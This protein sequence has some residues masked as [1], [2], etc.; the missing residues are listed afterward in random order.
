MS[1]SQV[2]A[3]RI[4]VTGAR[5]R[6]FADVAR[7]SGAFGVLPADSDAV[8]SEKF[9][10]YAIEANPNF[11]GDKGDPG[12]AANTYGSRAALA[13]SPIANGSAILAAPNDAGVFVWQ[14]GNFTD[15]LDVI[16]ST[17]V[18]ISQGGWVL[19]SVFGNGP[20]NLINFGLATRG[21]GFAVYYAI[22][23]GFTNLYIPEGTWSDVGNIPAYNT[24]NAKR[25]IRL[26][27]A[28]QNLTFIESHAPDQ[29]MA[30]AGDGGYIADF[31]IKGMNPMGAVL[32]FPESDV[33]NTVV[34]RVTVLQE[35]V[36][37][38]A[39]VY[40]AITMNFNG[41][42][43]AKNVILR[44]ITVIN[45]SRMG[46]EILAQLGTSK[47]QEEIL[48]EGFRCIRPQG[49][50][51][52]FNP[53]ISIDGTISGIR[54]HRFYS[55][56]STGSSIEVIK[57][58]NVEITDAVMVRPKGALISATNYDIPVRRL[59][60]SRLRVIEPTFPTT[61]F[62]P[63]CEGLIV[64]GCVM[65]N[66]QFFN[67]A[68]PDTIFRN[69]YLGCTVQYMVF[70]TNFEANGGGA[71]M[72]IANNI[73]DHRGYVGGGNDDQGLD[74]TGARGYIYADTP[75]AVGVTWI[76]NK[77]YKAPNTPAAQA[78]FKTQQNSAQ[79]VA[80][81]AYFKDGVFVASGL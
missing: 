32:T 33:S 81:G 64:E 67:G 56:D 62:M 47:V 19:S 57:A 52:A 1:L 76:G 50:P 72:H 8:V 13:A 61:L 49:Q 70:N 60:V 27:G 53:S 4:N 41:G 74:S 51:E 11:K 73:F 14:T 21:I 2:G 79:N 69:N 18:P 58:D 31:T 55:S 24:R 30:I 3:I 75:G 39:R 23:A 9:A 68:S 40:N 17:V 29:G 80:A 45:P 36:T 65:P 78:Y 42:G 6:S 59:R 5:G 43:K 37:D 71:R 35:P 34:E 44:D 48:I 12:A 15:R 22:Q 46:L 16:A 10:D 7:Q 26:V 38:P 77:C 63:S 66:T 54:V 28:G 20:V 25:G